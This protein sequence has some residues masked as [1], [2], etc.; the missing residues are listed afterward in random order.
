MELRLLR[1]KF[2]EDLGGLYPDPEIDA[3]FYVLTDFYLGLPRHILGLEPE[4]LISDEQAEQLKE[5]LVELSSGT[6]VQY[7]TGTAYFKGRNFAVGPGVL[8]PRPETEEL[9]DWVLGT[10]S[11][12][13]KDL[14][15]LDVGSGSGCIAIS[16]AIEIPEAQVHGL[17][18]SEMALDYA[19]KNESAHECSIIWHEADLFHPGNL[20]C[21]FNI[22]VS[23]PPYI[24]LAESEIMH[25]NVRDF[26]P[27][28]ALFVPNEDPLLFYKGLTAI[29]SDF[30]LEGGWLYLEIHER[31]FR[32]VQGLLI[33]SGFREVQVKND[34]FGKPRFVRGRR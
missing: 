4:K 8:I 28:M 16:L 26:E 12:K 15:I 2:R 10:C 25:P 7:V 11:K 6:P 14:H 27:A 31:L 18:K 21:R 5:A 3:L 20:G 23:N 30:L 17:E 13:Q 24:P 22:I 33:E 1:S 19:K 29:C 32:E 9:I 34:I